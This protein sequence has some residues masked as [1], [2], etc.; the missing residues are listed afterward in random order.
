M[1][2]V[3]DIFSFTTQV[4]GK[5]VGVEIAELLAGRAPQNA[6]KCGVLRVKARASI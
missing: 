6:T 2:P 5:N 3:P 1:L 4:K